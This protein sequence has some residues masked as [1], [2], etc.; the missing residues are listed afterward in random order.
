MEE[1]ELSSAAR[2]SVRMNLLC[3]LFICVFVYLFVFKCGYLATSVYILYR[4]TCGSVSPLSEVEQH[5]EG[6]VL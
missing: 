5:I 6:I 4:H 3:V 2:L 1:F